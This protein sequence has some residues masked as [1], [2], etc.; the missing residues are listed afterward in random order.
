MSKQ[1]KIT[2]LYERLSRD[3]EL[4]GESGSIQNQKTMLEAYAAQHGFC[5]VIHFTDDGFTG[6]NFDRP[7]WKTMIAE[8]EKGNVGTVIVKDMSRIGREYLQTGYYT[9]V[10]FREKGVRF[11]AIGN[12]IDSKNSESSEFAPFLNIMSEWFLRDTSRKIKAAHKANGMAGKRL[13][14]MPIY[15]YRLD[16]EDKSKWIIDPEA[17]EVVRRIFQLT[18][19]GKGPHKIARILTAEKILCPKQYKAAH[20]LVN[21]SDTGGSSVWSGTSI[22]DILKKPEYMGHTVNFRSAKESYKDKRSKERPREEW[23]IFEN[24]HPRIVDPETWETAQ[25]CRKTVRRT[26]S[27]GEA[28]PLT[29]LVFCA[30]CGA[31]LYNHR[32]SY[33]KTYVDKEGK[34]R[35]RSPKDEYTCSTYDLSAIRFGRTCT[36][37]YVRTATLRDLILDAIKRVS[38][39][40]KTNEA[41]F[42]RRVREDSAIREVE[43]VKAHRRRL[44][45]EEKRI[46]ELNTLIRRI[47]EDN[48]SGKLTDKRFEALSQEYEQEQ[49]ELESSAVQI[50]AELNTFAAD[51]NRAESFIEIVKRHNDFSELTS[52]MIAEYIERIVV[53]QA[54]KSGGERE[55]DV[56]IFLNFIGKFEVPMPEPSQGEIEAEEFARYKRTRH[57]EAQ[58]RYAA[59]RRAKRTRMKTA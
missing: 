25:R 8:I 29:G 2:A 21:Y 51:G 46:T 19:E 15:G 48:V 53:H 28:N 12:N 33:A 36:S 1:T 39:F 57:R 20:G 42:I 14:F 52:A 47:Y 11:I 45:R 27:T 50:R 18:I 23:V 56:E 10:F 49:A 55:Q 13:T 31:K 38:E 37:H 54:D 44:A 4:H 43:T 17:A 32:R 30:D 7:G 16:P 9:E 41:E 22:S 34:T 35:T 6:G 40:V 59:N 24:T 3:D 5:N 26:D 58:R